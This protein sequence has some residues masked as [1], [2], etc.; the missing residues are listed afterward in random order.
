[1][2]QIRSNQLG[3]AWKLLGDALSLIECLPEEIAQLNIPAKLVQ[4][5]ADVTLG[6][7]DLVHIFIS[8]LLQSKTGF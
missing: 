6:K 5:D 7:W 8:K 2:L 3:C 4:K 1:V